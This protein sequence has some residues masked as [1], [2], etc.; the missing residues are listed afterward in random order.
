MKLLSFFVLVAVVVASDRYG[1]STEPFDVTDQIT[2]SEV[3]RRYPYLRP[4]MNPDVMYQKVMELPLDLKR[5]LHMTT[6]NI[7][8]GRGDYHCYNPCVRTDLLKTF[9]ENRY[10]SHN[11]GDLWAVIYQRDELHFRTINEFI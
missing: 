7:K 2:V 9:L 10:W 5:R 6:L 4:N 11:I 3:L 1:P 8:D